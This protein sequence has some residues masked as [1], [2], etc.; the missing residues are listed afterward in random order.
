[1]PGSAPPEPLLRAIPTWRGVDTVLGLV[2]ELD[3]SDTHTVREAVLR[4]LARKPDTL[5]LDLSGLTF[6]GAAGI[7]C[8]CWALGRAEAD[9]V[10]FRIVAAPSWLCRVLTATEDYDLLAAISGPPRPAPAPA[11]RVI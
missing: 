6:C 2:G 4:C 10:E 1:M 8:L 3:A 7:H 5:S 9:H 11:Q